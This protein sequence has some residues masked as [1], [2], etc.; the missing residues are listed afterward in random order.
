MTVVQSAPERKSRQSTN[1][2]WT[3]RCLALTVIARFLEAQD[4]GGKKRLRP[5]PLKYRD[6]AHRLVARLDESN[7]EI[8]VRE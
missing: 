6:A 5:T 7:L 3:N 8:R 4:N 1:K 2:K